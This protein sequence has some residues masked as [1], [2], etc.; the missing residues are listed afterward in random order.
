MIGLDLPP[1]AALAIVPGTFAALGGA[2][3]GGAYMGYGASQ[4]SPVS[5]EGMYFIGG[6]LAAGGVSTLS[7]LSF[8]RDGYGSS[9]A[10]ALFVAGAIGAAA[11]MP[12][13]YGLGYVAGRL[14]S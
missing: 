7:P 1:W 14:T 11:L 9:F 4:G 12:I 5:P 10:P 6:S 13:G 8:P 3:A 2:L